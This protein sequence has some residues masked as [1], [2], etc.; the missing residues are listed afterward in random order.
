MCPKRGNHFSKCE[1]FKPCIQ[2]LERLLNL[3]RK[4][5]EHRKIFIVG[6]A[7]SQELWTEHNES[8]VE[9]I[10]TFISEK[11][12]SRANMSYTQTN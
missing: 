8:Y 11:A 6:L 3:L 1:L 10:P 2:N 12:T 4:P 7:I 9:K 5:H